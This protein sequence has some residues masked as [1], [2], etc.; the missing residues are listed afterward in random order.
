M[1]TIDSLAKEYADYLKLNFANPSATSEIIRR[2]NGLTYTGTGNKLSVSD[3]EKL[4]GEIERQINLE[5]I[6]P[7][8]QFISLESED[9]RQLLQLIQMIRKGVE[10]S[11]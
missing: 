11:K 6:T 9:S 2:I 5:N 10:G 4:V 3:R 7:D 1:A 8:G